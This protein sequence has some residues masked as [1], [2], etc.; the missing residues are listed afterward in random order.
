MALSLALVLGIATQAVDP[1]YA[2]NITVFHVNEHKYGA[3]PVNMNTADA[4]GDVIFDLLEVL[5]SPIGR[6]TRRGTVVQI[7]AQI[8]KPWALT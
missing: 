6:Q 8:P 2:Q 5:I 1:K 3:I 7:L 4:I